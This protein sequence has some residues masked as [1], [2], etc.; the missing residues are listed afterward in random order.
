MTRALL[1]IAILLTLAPLGACASDPTR[2]YAMGVAYDDS[3]RTIAVPIFE[4]STIE[5]GLEVALTDAIIKQIQTRTPWRIA[6]T[7]NADTTLTGA[8]TEHRLT[9][10]SQTPRTGLVQEQ[11][12]TLSIRYEWADNRTGDL[13]SARGAFS[14]TATFVPQRGI[15]ER[16]EHAQ[17]EAIDELAR[18]LVEQLRARW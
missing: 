8:L 11:G 9:Q 3:V 6:R 1:T 14:A 2:G 15:G 12:V 7:D 18:D 13:L 10:L 4:N 5:R 16:L 17:R